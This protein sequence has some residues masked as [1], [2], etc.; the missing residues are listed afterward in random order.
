MDS[1]SLEELR[2]SDST[3]LKELDPDGERALVERV[4]RAAKRVFVRTNYQWAIDRPIHYQ[5]GA[6]AAVLSVHGADCGTDFLF[7]SLGRLVTLERREAAQQ[8]IEVTCIDELL[9]IL[10]RD[11]EFRFVSPAVLSQKYDGTF[12][13]YRI[14]TWFQRFFCAVYWESA[15]PHEGMPR[16]P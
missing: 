9:D 15:R 6:L 5:D 14:G 4:A 8:N 13:R 3:A 1:L 12:K 16:W 7:S 10:Q 2:Q 11:Y